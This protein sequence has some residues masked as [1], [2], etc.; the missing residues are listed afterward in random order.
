MGSCWI[1]KG[2]T[3]LSSFI[4][5]LPNQEFCYKIQH[6]WI[7]FFKIRLYGFK[8]Q[9]LCVS[10]KLWE[11]FEMFLGITYSKLSLNI[12][13]IVKFLNIFPWWGP[14]V[15]LF[16]GPLGRSM[17]DAEHR[18]RTNI[19]AESSGH[20]RI[21]WIFGLIAKHEFNVNIN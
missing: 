2:E 5:S 16:K 10:V 8:I 9:Q 6:V 18:H 20:R 14:G 1:Y 21:C 13:I 7:D 4:F 3:L 19:G 11:S 12:P 17:P 15:L